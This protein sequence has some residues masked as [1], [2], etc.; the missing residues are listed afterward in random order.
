[1]NP[2]CKKCGKKM[3]LK[4]GWGYWCKNTVCSNLA[5]IEKKGDLK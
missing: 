1:M 3:T 2:T 5:V 4:K